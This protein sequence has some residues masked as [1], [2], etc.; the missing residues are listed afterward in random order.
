LAS[1]PAFKSWLDQLSG[2]RER[3]VVYKNLP[4]IPSKLLR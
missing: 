4:N 1:E 2:A 3:A